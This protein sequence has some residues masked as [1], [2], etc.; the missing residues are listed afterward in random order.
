MDDEFELV[1]E[2]L[3]NG[4][5]SHL[6]AAFATGSGP[7]GHSKIVAWYEEGRFHQHPDEA[8]EALTCACFLGERETA[9]YLILKGL[10]PSGGGRT[11]MNA[12]HWAAN[13]GQVETLRLLLRHRVPLETRNMYGG[14]VL[15]QTVWSAVNQPGP[16]QLEAIAELLGAGADLKAVELPTGDP[17][18][19]AVLSRGRPS[20]SA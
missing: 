4:D 16:G 15:G 19:D 2:G 1:L 8:A 14:T 18:V 9:E 3:R 6:A 12:V 10:D 17:R 5:F 7:P 20:S 11:G 13:R